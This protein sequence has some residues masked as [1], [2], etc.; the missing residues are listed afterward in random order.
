LVIR[1][2]WLVAYHLLH[3]AAMANSEVALAERPE[4]CQISGAP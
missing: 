2:F 1:A 4:L 3:S